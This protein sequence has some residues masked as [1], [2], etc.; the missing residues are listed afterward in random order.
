MVESLEDIKGREER[1]GCIY[2]GYTRQCHH[3]IAVGKRNII[4]ENKDKVCEEGSRNSHTPGRPISPSL[5]S[6]ANLRPLAS[7]LFHISAQI[8][9]P[10]PLASSQTFSITSFQQLPSKDP[11]LP[12][13][14]V[15]YSSSYFLYPD[16]SSR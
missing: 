10:V 1:T 5:I 15:P 9:E 2:Y 3:C 12:A 13:L 14:Y 16:T 4:P 6:W 8:P 11:K 7:H